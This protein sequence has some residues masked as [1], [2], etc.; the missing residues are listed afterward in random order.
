MKAKDVTDTLDLALSASGLDKMTVVHRPRL[1][2][3]HCCL[4]R[5]ARSRGIDRLSQDGGR[6]ASAVTLTP[7]PRVAPALRASGLAL[8][9]QHWLS[10]GTAILALCDPISS[11]HARQPL[12]PF[13]GIVSGIINSAIAELRPTRMAKS[14]FPLG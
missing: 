12:P 1:G 4:G 14:R 7:P 9:A 5:V 8:R 2:A 11:A 3:D 13:F 10:S 6:P